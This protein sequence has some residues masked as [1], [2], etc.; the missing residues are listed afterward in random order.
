M[1]HLNLHL[2]DRAVLV[3]AGVPARALGP[4][5]YTLVCVIHQDRGMNGTLVIAGG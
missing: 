2:N 5:R 1:M 4:G 3:R